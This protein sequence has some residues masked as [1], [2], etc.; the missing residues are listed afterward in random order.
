[1]NCT[2]CH[3]GQCP[4]IDF[5]DD[6]SPSDETRSRSDS[7]VC[8]DCHEITFREWEDYI[9]ARGAEGE[10]PTCWGCHMSPS[11]GI[12]SARP[13]PPEE[14]VLVDEGVMHGSHV[15]A[16]IPESGIRLEVSGLRRTRSNEWEALIL[17]Y[18]EAA[19]H[20]LPSGAYGYRELRLEFW[21]DERTPDS[22][23][24]RRFFSEMGNALFP[25][26]NGPFIFRVPG[27]GARLSARV[28][29]VNEGEST[30]LDETTQRLPG[31]RTSK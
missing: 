12:S 18:N 1:V 30:V 2:A 14:D 10:K 5:L 8:G 27:E 25:G 13:A 15:F 17:V 29:R 19:G 26:A 28:I 11:A 3:G 22:M 20:N 7:Q 21:V 9:S 6:H 31:M 24:I 16:K 4:E 23:Q